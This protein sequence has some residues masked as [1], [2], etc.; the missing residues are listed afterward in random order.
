MSR[1]LLLSFIPL[2]LF[3]T[4]AVA[5]SDSFTT[6]YGRTI[7]LGDTL[8]M[9]APEYTESFYLTELE[10]NQFNDYKNLVPAEIQSSHYQPL[11]V[12]SLPQNLALTYYGEHKPITAVCS[13]PDGARFFIDIDNAVYKNE[14][15]M[16]TRYND[17]YR[18]I[19]KELT[20]LVKLLYYIHTEQVAIDD[21][22]ILRYILLVNPELG[23][24]CEHDK[25]TFRREKDHYLALLQAD[26]MTFA[27]EMDKTVY[28]YPKKMEAK[29][30]NDATYNP[31]INGYLITN[32]YNCESSFNTGYNTPDITLLYQPCKTTLEM[33]EAKAEQYERKLKGTGD[34]LMRQEY[35]MVYVNLMSFDKK[36]SPADKFVCALF[37]GAE[38]FDHPSCM[39]NYLGNISFD[40]QHYDN[41]LKQQKKE[42]RQ[43]KVEAA[44]DVAGGILGILSLF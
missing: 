15:Q 14:I 10:G 6:Y 7:H 2:L 16:G 42:L 21:D 26:L 8:W 17:S 39:Y 22:A 23:K 40:P 20:D 5:Q 28:Y 18:K 37:L 1:R 13:T 27:Q 11:V 43:K 4:N 32:L 12:D 19:Y 35:A 44:S 36:A 38:L 3:A 24:T 33:P 34:F 25:F 41:V 9:G 29:I 31:D 30:G